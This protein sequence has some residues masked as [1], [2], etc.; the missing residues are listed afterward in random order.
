M[1]VSTGV[2]CVYLLRLPGWIRS[3]L[4]IGLKLKAI[5]SF[6]KIALQ[7]LHNEKATHPSL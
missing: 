4:P 6:I 5:W 7:K 3:E 1:S 2:F